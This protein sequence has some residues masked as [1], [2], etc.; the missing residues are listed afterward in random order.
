LVKNI[1]ERIVQILDGTTTSQEKLPA[2]KVKQQLIVTLLKAFS[3]Y[4]TNSIL[5]NI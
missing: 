1:G 4:T 2:E 3:E 5:L